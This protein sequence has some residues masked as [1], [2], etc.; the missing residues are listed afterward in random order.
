MPQNSTK[1]EPLQAPSSAGHVGAEPGI[2]PRRT[3][4]SENYG[5]FKQDCI[6][7]VA[8]YT[9]N[10]I[11][12]KR[13][14]NAEF[15]ELLK[16]PYPPHH[17]PHMGSTGSLRTGVRWVN[18]GG[19]D[20]GVMSALAL[21]Y[22]AEPPISYDPWYLSSTQPLG[23]PSFAGVRR[24]NPRAGAYPLQGGLLPR[25]SVHPYPL[26]LTRSESRPRRR[27]C[28]FH[29]QIPVCRLERLDPRARRPPAC[30]PRGHGKSSPISST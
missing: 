12:V 3:S 13:L 23:R 27:H 18:I 26:P 2:N 20:W 11:S 22:G 19:I 17:P 9:T 1:P 14:G 5:H 15:V 28:G 24:R 29:A 30:P 25:A 6:I 7:E 4:A 21:K 10:D 16:E 8:D